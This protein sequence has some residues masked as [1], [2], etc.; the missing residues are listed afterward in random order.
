MTISNRIEGSLRLISP[1]HCATADK[2]FD[3]SETDSVTK[4]HKFKLTTATGIQTIPYFPGNDAR[5]RLRREAATLVLDHL[6]ANAKVSAELY[7]GL[8]GGTVT[9]KPEADLSIEEALR[10]RD[11][12]YMGL[13]GGGTRLLRSRYTVNDLIPI[14]QDTI[15]GGCV[16]A[17]FGEAGVPKGRIG[18]GLV[19][20]LTGYHLLE[21]RTSFKLDDLAQALRPDELEKYLFDAVNTVGK[22][23]EQSLADSAQRKSD[24]AAAKAGEIDASDV[25]KKKTLWNMFA[26]ESIARGTSMYFLT[27]LANDVSDAQV[28]L[29]LLALQSLVRKQNLGGWIRCGYGRYSADLTLTR[30]GQKYQIFVAGKN[31]DDATLTDEVQKAFGKPALD[32]ISALTAESMIEFFTAKAKVKEKKPAKATKK[33]KGAAAEVTA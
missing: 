15:D 20:P 6:T 28:G 25:T 4:T 14:V 13:F 31:A 3:P 9:T 12:I 5:G 22:I 2:S 19:G 16:P 27:D 18:D 26:V 21:A 10:A 24:K 1:L 23:Q 7:Q 29:L 32:A 17:S 33:D 11:N 30:N 8:T